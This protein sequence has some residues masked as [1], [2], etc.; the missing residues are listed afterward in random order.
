MRHAL[1]WTDLRGRAVGVW[2]LGVE[3]RA[4]VRRLAALG[5][6]PVLVDDRP[7]PD[8]LGPVLT[9][10][11][12]GLDALM[13]C[14]VVVKSPGISHYR[15]EVN[16]LEA[17]GTAVVGGLGLWLQEADGDRV[18][19][20]TGT[21]GKSTV[22]SVAAHLAGRLGLRVATGG[23]IGTAPFD[24][25]ASTDV[26]LWFVETSSYQAREVARSPRV[27]GVTSLS[28]DHLSWHQGVE[29]YFADKL[30][31]CSQPGAE[32]TVA[33]ASSPAL[34]A[35]AGALAPR[36]RWVGADDVARAAR[37]CGGLGLRGDHNI[38]NAA[39]ARVLLAEVGVAGADDEAALATA[40]EGF[41]PLAARLETVALVDGVEFV[42]DGLSTNAL[43]TIAALAAFPD[44][45]VALLVGGDDRGI[46]YAPLAAAVV[47]HPTPVLVLT[48][49]RTGPRVADAVRRALALG[50]R[51][52][53]APATTEVVEVDG[54]AAAVPRAH[55]WAG[56]GGVVLLSPAAPSFD[57][58]RDYR[59]RSEAYRA[60]I[61]ALP[62]PDR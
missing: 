40:A 10:A 27:V 39:L 59:D 26:D 8:V 4:A 17:G 5:V 44:R 3:G 12:G 24:P 14:D 16:L 53:R 58:F 18:V 62:A 11:Q 30:S 9:T 7:A 34:V 38:E 20:I 50:Q 60:A 36:V 41:S 56:P 37:W 6:T 46:D 15:P 31:L 45:R 13:G 19:C 61:D 28:P 1:S 42:D 25:D 52:D 35:R 48:S 55:V 47:S 33:S 32:V 49:Y 22:T 57:A 54:L 2:G 23:N 21:K 43:P 51:E 29:N